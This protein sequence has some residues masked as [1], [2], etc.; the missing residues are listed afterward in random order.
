M[1]NFIS[2]FLYAGTTGWGNRAAYRAAYLYN[3]LKLS[4]NRCVFQYL[5]CGGA[6]ILYTGDGFLHDAEQMISYMTAMGKRRLSGQNVLQV[7]H[8]GSKHN[9]H[10]K[11]PNIL[12]PFGVVYCSNPFD[13]RYNH[14]HPEVR[15]WFAGYAQ[16]QVDTSEGAYVDIKI[17]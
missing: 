5:K 12:G 15:A 17:W 2:L 10:P 6:G 13:R 4:N 9:C 1:R 16:M 7:M 11:L 3:A 14:P 8:H